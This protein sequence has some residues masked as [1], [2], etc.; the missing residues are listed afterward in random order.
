MRWAIQTNLGSSRD[1]ETLAETCRAQGCEVHLIT[2]PPF[3]TDP[4]EVPTDAPTVFYGSSSLIDAV[5]HANRWR[6]GAWTLADDYQTWIA[7]Y[8]SHML[9]ADARLLSMGQLACDDAL[10]RDTRPIF[11]RPCNDSKVFAGH[12]TPSCDLVAWARRALELGD[13]TLA[14]ETRVLLA[15]PVGLRDEW[16]LFVVDGQV[17]T[18]SHY[19][20]YQ[21]L[22]VSPGVPDE[23]RC[24][25]E[26]LLARESPSPVVVMD[27]GRSGDGLFVIEF[28]GACSSGFYAA[29]LSAFVAAVGQ[30]VA[31]ASSDATSR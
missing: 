1:A 28:N 21:R 7:T 4:P 13:S 17:V 30:F 3:C 2:R 12:I 25:A 26:E 19:R 15:E 6:P 16:R 20:T 5:V 10:A 31:V 14:A 18:G 24:F 29:D 11:A 9:N 23:V 27:V 8:G 22:D